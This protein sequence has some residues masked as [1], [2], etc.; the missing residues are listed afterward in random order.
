MEKWGQVEL[1][2]PEHVYLPT[3]L[4]LLKLRLLNHSQDFPNLNPGNLAWNPL[5]EAVAAGPL[6]MTVLPQPGS[7]DTSGMLTPTWGVRKNHNG[8]KALWSQ[9][10]PLSHVPILFQPK[11]KWAICCT[12]APFPLDIIPNLLNVW[13]TG[14]PQPQAQ[15]QGQVE[16][17]Q[18]CPQWS[19]K[20]GKLLRFQARD[21]ENYFPAV[22]FNL[23]FLLGMSL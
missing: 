22:F 17:R 18:F 3:T 1:V 8:H 21:S 10:W 15:I 23:D 13:M 2:V 9:I 20:N 19:G 16:G 14:P 5:G 4:K 7:G 11:I 6:G 12:L